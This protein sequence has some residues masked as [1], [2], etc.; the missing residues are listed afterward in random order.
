[1]LIAVLFLSGCSTVANHFNQ[2]D[3][4]LQAALHN[5]SMPSWCGASNNRIYI[6]DQSGQ[7]QAY[8]ITP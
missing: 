4:C 6:Y 2:Q 5:T 3:P 8:I 7:R 1:M